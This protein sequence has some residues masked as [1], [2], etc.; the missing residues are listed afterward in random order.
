MAKKVTLLDFCASEVTTFGLGLSKPFKAHHIVG[1]TLLFGQMIKTQQ[2]S[3]HS[4]VS[5]K[6]SLPLHKGS[7]YLAKRQQKT[8]W[9]GNGKPTTWREKSAFL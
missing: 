4:Q 3:P 8:N 7:L 5:K 2:L 9:C 1:I 6:V